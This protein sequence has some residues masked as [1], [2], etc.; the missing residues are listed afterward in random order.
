MRDVPASDVDRLG[1]LEESVWALVGFVHLA[2]SGALTAE[3]L[4]PV[5]AQDAAAA[6]L[7]RAVG[8]IDAGGEPTGVLGDVVQ[9]G[10]LELRRQAAISTLRQ[11]ATAT[12]VE[13]GGAP[14]WAIQDDETLLAQ[15]RASAMAGRMMAAMVV[16]SLDGLAE[17]F[18]DG[19]QF[20]DVGV[21]VAGL[22][23]AFCEM[24]PTARV[25]GIDVMPRVLD[26][27]RRTIAEH[28]LGDRLDVQLVG[29]EE[30]DEHGRFDLAWMP[31]PFLPQVVFGPGLRRVHDALRPGGW[32]IV[33][34]GRFEGDPLAVAVTRWKTLASG[35]TPL[36]ADDADAE[37]GAAGFT[38][39]RELPTP[40]GS[41][42]VYAARRPLAG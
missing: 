29:V 1:Q 15:G 3:G 5:T 9:G 33:G 18:A 17:R 22:S 19:G 16:P 36:T 31:A 11:A 42:V 23:A 40:P 24:V 2:G 26:L 35:G 37:L 34:A 10:L 6:E 27:A 14:G 25:L 30:L 38:D 12:T 13:P 21:G 32:L 28:D 39:L 41:P 8:L 7:L 4:H 20:L